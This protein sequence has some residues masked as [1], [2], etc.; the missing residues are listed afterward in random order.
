MKRTL[1][2]LEENGS[3]TCLLYG[4]GIFSK[5]CSM[6]IFVSR[7]KKFTIYL[8]EHSAALTRRSTLLRDAA[9]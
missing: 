3:I 6:A 7:R 5:F 1:M 4:E 8:Q 9:L 2:R